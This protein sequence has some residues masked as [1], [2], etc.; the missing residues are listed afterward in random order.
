MLD[1]NETADKAF[2]KC[3]NTY[4]TLLCSYIDN[5]EYVATEAFLEKI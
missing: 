3:I 1:I 5:S 4:L 2:S